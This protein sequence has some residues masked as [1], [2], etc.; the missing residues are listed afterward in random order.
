MGN[1]LTREWRGGFPILP[2]L[3]CVCAFSTGYCTCSFLN[4]CV[5][6]TTRAT[7]PTR[8]GGMCCHRRRVGAWTHRTIG[9]FTPSDSVFYT[10]QKNKYI[11]LYSAAE[12]SWSSHLYSS[13]RVFIHC[14]ASMCVF[15]CDSIVSTWL[16]L[17]SSFLLLLLFTTHSIFPLQS[18]QTVVK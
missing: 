16:S 6:T 1:Q 18:F 12:P 10:Q 2:F 13:P 5:C 17:L 11:F 9:T 8:R 4:V 3:S 14:A 7:V 15:I